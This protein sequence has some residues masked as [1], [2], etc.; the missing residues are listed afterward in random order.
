[1]GSFRFPG[2][3]VARFS[4]LTF[5]NLVKDYLFY[6][7]FSHLNYLI[8]C[9]KVWCKLI[10]EQKL[11]LEILSRGP[12]KCLVIAKHPLSPTYRR[13]DFLFT[14]LEEFPFAILYFTGSKIF[15]T[16]MRHIAL[17]MGLTMNEHGLY[18]LQNKEKE[19][20][21]KEKVSH[22]FESEKDIFHYLGLEYKS[23]EQRIDGRAIIQNN[24]TTTTTITSKDNKN[25][26]IKKNTTLKKKSVLK[27]ET[28]PKIT[29]ENNIND[30]KKIIENFKNNGI[31]FLNNLNE[32]QLSSVIKEASVALSLRC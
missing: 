24:K 4:G 9:F 15:N 23:P 3:P 17:Q 22:K 26:I 2:Y 7:N 14:S 21:K 27:T 1:L 8:D 29:I 16:V 19:Q 20:D 12:S 11:I 5:K 10:F 13:V 6:L 25:T 30:T 28:K 32:S 18:Y 31:T